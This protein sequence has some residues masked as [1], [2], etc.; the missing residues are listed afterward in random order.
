MRRLALFL[1]MSASI[2]A[3]WFAPTSASA[4]TQCPPVFQDSGCQFLIVV[5]NGGTIVESNPALGPYES[6]DDALVGIEN[7]SSAPLTSIHLSA[8]DALFGFEGDGICNPGGA[9]VPPGC[10]VPSE[11][12]SVNE[13]TK[14]HEKNPNAGKE[15][16]YVGE[17]K[18]GKTVEESFEGGCAFPAPAGEPVGGGLPEFASIIGYSNG[19]PVT[20]YE[21]PTSWFTNIGPF[22]ESADGSGTVN[23]SPALEPG[24]FTYFSLESPPAGGF[25][26]SSALS[27]TLSGGGQSGASLSAV[28]GTPV[29]D[30][31]SLGG[32]NSGSAVGVVTYN[33]Y[34]DAACKTLVAAAGSGAMAGGKSAPSSAESLAPGK[35][36]W[37]ATYGGD[38]NN[39]ATAS[40]CGGEILTVLSATKTATSQTAGPATGVSL[41]VRKGTPVTD[42][43]TITGA[44]AAT[45]TGSVTYTLFKD[46]KCTIPA[47]AGSVGAVVG[48]VA[49]SS[50][51]V[52]P[53]VGTYYWGASY[54]GDAVNGPSASTCGSEILV[55]ALKAKLGLSSSHGCLSKRRFVVHPRGPRGVKLVHVEVLINGVLKAQGPLN[56]GHTLV[57]LAGLPK[58][59][60]QVELVVTSSSGKLYEDVRTFH[61]CVPKKHKKH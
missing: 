10:Q 57:S 22:G 25:G 30:T 21:G 60:Y 8:E 3:V 51:P 4:F 54:S 39:Q 15:C 23:F 53:G 50:T 46:N 56:K 5:T 17:V 47:G 52:V 38:I 49:A 43:A 34:G 27:T 20:G 55:V 33:V 12:T 37:Q 59:T 35:Y 48:G 2:G 44:L 24:Q 9:P 58:G 14:K 29:T 61:T 13:E 11:T 7:K 6:S 16:G 42:K 45:A 19:D 32:V 1:F 26:S 18:N 28:Q 31:A 40:V 36:Y 41:T